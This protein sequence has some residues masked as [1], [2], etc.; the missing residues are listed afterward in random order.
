MAPQGDTVVH[1]LIVLRPATYYWRKIV[2]KTFI[3]KMI[4]LILP[5]R[6]PMIDL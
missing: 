6:L 4:F 5:S 3:S 1:A 2:F